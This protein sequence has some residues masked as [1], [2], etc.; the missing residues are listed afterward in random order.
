[1]CEPTILR[2]K[3]WNEVNLLSFRFQSLGNILF[4]L[5]GYKRARNFYYNENIS[6]SYCIKLTRIS[7]IV[8]RTCYILRIE[9][10]KIPANIWFVIT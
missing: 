3:R 4:L 10:I 7:R 8:E 1:M 6:N 9:E 5:Q 2:I